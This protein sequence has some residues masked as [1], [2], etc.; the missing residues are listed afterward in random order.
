MWGKWSDHWR[1][2][3]DTISKKPRIQLKEE[4][5]FNFDFSSN[6]TNTS[7]IETALVTKPTPLSTDP[8]LV[9]L[10][11]QPLHTEESPTVNGIEPVC[12]IPQDSKYRICSF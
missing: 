10:R 2:G 3:C 1:H 5:K 8:D 9:N 12:K 7:L 11:L 4:E 6:L